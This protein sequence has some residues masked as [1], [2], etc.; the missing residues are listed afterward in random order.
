MRSAACAGQAAGVLRCQPASR[1]CRAAPP[2]RRPALRTTPPAAPASQ[3]RARRGGGC[4][5]AL[6]SSSQGDSPP[7][8]DDQVRAR[9]RSERHRSPS[10]ASLGGADAALMSSQW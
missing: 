8:N 6:D 4:L 5:A 1:R 7:P 9:G 2:A 10:L 3:D